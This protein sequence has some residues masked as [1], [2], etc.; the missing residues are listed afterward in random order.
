MLV[1]DNRGSFY[2]SQTPASLLTCL[3]CRNIFYDLQNPV[4][5]QSQHWD[6]WRVISTPWLKPLLVL[7]LEPINVV[8]YDET[9]HT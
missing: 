1:F 7:H 8:V 2:C 6:G 4:K 5:G 9:T 3:V